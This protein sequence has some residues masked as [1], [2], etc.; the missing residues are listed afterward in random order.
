M[1][2]VNHA[3]SSIDIW[4]PS[5][6]NMKTAFATQ[7]RRTTLQQY[8]PIMLITRLLQAMQ[9]NSRTACRIADTIALTSVRDCFKR[10]CVKRQ[11][12]FTLIEL[13]VTIAVAGI[14]LSVAIPSFR[15]MTSDSRIA[16]EA[17]CLSRALYAARSEPVKRAERVTVC[18]RA[19]DGSCGDDWTRG[20]LVFTDGAVGADDENAIIDTTD[21]I[22]RT[23][24]AF[25]TDNSIKV[26]G[27]TSR[28][29]AGA[30]DRTHIRFGPSGRPNWK[31][32]YFVICDERSADNWA[33]IN[34]TLSGSLNRARLNPDGDALLNVFNSDI[35]TCE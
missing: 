33:G 1:V 4:L 3:Y 22:L 16:A 13:L 11:S 31:N 8:T 21:T 18:A 6:R 12:G 25:T 9:L 34:V 28:T 29:A 5:L 2:P 17:D 35:T 14:L 27:S 19:T 32:G 30:G 10:R 20:A 24:P 23:C 15:D 7:V 26:E